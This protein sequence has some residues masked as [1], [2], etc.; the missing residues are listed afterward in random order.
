MATIENK[1]GS[2]Y[3]ESTD[4]PVKVTLERDWWDEE[5]TLT[6][7]IA[8]VSYNVELRKKDLKALKKEIKAA[9]AEL[10]DR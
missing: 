5:Y 9:L 2:I 7:E 3:A 1:T 8:D 4:Q 10:K 6:L